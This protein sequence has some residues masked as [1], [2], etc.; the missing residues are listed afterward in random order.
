M[1][2]I[3]EEVINLNESEKSDSDSDVEMENVVQSPKSRSV[4]PVFNLKTET[5]IE[6]SGGE[7]LLIIFKFKA[8]NLLTLGYKKLTKLCIFFILS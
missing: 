6:L 3:S 7:I 1:K 4:S 8:F 5:C 2:D